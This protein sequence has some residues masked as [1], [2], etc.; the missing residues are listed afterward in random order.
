MA[1]RG[2]VGKTAVA[3]AKDRATNR[4]GAAVVPATDGAALQGF[5]R[6]RSELGAKVYTYDAPAVL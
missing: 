4:A 3:G 2:A 5:V 6:E 1:G